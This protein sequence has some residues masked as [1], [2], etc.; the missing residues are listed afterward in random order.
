MKRHPC[1]ECSFAVPAAK[2][3]GSIAEINPDKP[4]EYCYNKGPLGE[5]KR[6]DCPFL[7]PVISYC[8]TVPE[9]NKRKTLPLGLVRIDRVITRLPDS[10][11]PLEDCWVIRNQGHC[12]RRDGQWEYEP[13]PPGKGESFRKNCE[14]TLAE[15]TDIL[16]KIMKTL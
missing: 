15:A 2:S 10:T 12:F 5:E 11:I 7:F 8:A 16:Q 9:W 1:Y 14:Y 4:P 13:S 6:S 3:W